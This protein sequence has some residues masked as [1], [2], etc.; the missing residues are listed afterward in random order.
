MQE[1]N[2]ISIINRTNNQVSGEKANALPVRV[3]SNLSWIQYI[4][5]G[6]VLALGVV[7]YLIS[8][9]QQKVVTVEVS[10]KANDFKIFE[11]K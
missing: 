9:I 1:E 7:I 2:S 4:L 11:V 6:F 3:M 5:I 10:G 8:T